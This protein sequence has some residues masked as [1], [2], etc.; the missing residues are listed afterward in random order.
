MPIRLVAACITISICPPAWAGQVAE[1]LEALSSRYDEIL[2]GSP[3]V[4]D[5]ADA[6][7]IGSHAGAVFVL[8]RTGVTAQ[9]D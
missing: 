2:V 5:S 8:T 6:L 9:T 7:T 1:I 4:L 3:S